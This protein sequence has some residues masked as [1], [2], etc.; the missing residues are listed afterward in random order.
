MQKVTNATEGGRLWSLPPIELPTN[1]LRPL[2]RPAKG[3]HAPVAPRA[4]CHWPQSGEGHSDTSTLVMF[5][6]TLHASTE[7]RRC[8]PLQQARRTTGSPDVRNEV[9]MLAEEIAVWTVVG[10][11]LLLVAAMIWRGD[12]PPKIDR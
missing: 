5:S 8:K 1:P 4:G 10:I 3:E 2:P 12:G 6:R 11:A 7:L 9:D